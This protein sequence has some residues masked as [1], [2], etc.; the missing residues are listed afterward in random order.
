[1]LGVDVI[2]EGEDDLDDDGV[3]GNDEDDISDTLKT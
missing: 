2:L 3:N 1:M